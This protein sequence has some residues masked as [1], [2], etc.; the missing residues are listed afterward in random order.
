M[1]R[2]KSGRSNG[3]RSSPAASVL[4]GSNRDGKAVA[5]KRS[6]KA[7]VAI[8]SLPGPP[9]KR[10]R[11]SDWPDA[12]LS[13]LNARLPDYSATKGNR[14]PFWTR[15][16][17]DFQEKFP[18]YN[19]QLLSGSSKE[20]G[21]SI[22]DASNKRLTPDLAS[23]TS[24]SSNPD[25]A[26][27]SDAASGV[28]ETPSLTN[29]VDVEDPKQPAQENEK[30]GTEDDEPLPDWPKTKAKIRYWVYN[31]AKDDKKVSGWQHRMQSYFK[32]LRRPVRVPTYKF[33]MKHP[34]FQPK[35][36]AEFEER[37]LDGLEDIDD[38]EGL[39]DD[40]DMEDSRSSDQ[41]QGSA[42]EENDSLEED[43]QYYLENWSELSDDEKRRVLDVYLIAMRCL[44]AKELF[45]AEKKS[46]RKSIE[47]E[48]EASYE[49]KLAEYKE[50]KE[51]KARNVPEIPEEDL[52][53]LTTSLA[54]DL[55]AMTGMYVS[56]VVGKPPKKAGE[57]CIIESMHAGVN[58][59][60]KNWA[61][62]DR[63][64]V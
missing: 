34:D 55:H 47:K 52:V 9:K 18:Q 28:A 44:V 24:S 59:E 19:P 36:A 51:L 62:F 58:S 21:S 15:L 31:H 38:L 6:H 20:T 39:E 40:E 57:K 16:Y 64:K 4:K 11:R 48:S 26:S 54:E 7:K 1:A 50:R 33:Y 17:S 29:S 10:G 35:V 46:V 53:P 22:V 2:T 32:P 30:D 37:F 45:E 43:L 14:G 63:E 61:D 56:I 41:D 25:P 3:K 12:E 49:A 42:V 23:T 13:F 8:G 5:A 27:P 60:G